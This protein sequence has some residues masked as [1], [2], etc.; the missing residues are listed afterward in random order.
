MDRLL[1]T[2]KRQRVPIFLA[3]TGNIQCEV[4]VWKNISKKCVN[5]NS[6]KSTKV[7]LRLFK[8]TP[9]FCLVYLFYPLSWKVV[10]K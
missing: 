7:V 6:V 1:Y 3:D 10:Q 9:T 4:G 5:I 8:S 2:G